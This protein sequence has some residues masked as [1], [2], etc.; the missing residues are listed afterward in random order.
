MHWKAEALDNFEC[1]A[2]GQLTIP[3]WNSQQ[4]RTLQGR[5]N[6]FQTALTALCASVPLCM[7][8]SQAC[9][10][11]RV[12]A[13]TCVYPH[14][15]ISVCVS[16]C[17]I[18]FHTFSVAPKHNQAMTSHS[19][20]LPLHLSALVEINS[21]LKSVTLCRCYTY[22]ICTLLTLSTF[23]C[24]WVIWVPNCHVNKKTGF[25]NRR[26][27]SLSRSETVSYW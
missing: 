18:V 25:H 17:F 5:L 6:A 8:C 12:P 2:R 14:L 24:S 21:V 13:Q 3:Q 11:V 9:V 22:G 23:T 1:A 15:F 26:S 4:T 19:S 10:S 27:F 16:V 7:Q 20:R